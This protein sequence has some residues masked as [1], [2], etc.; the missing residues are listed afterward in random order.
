MSEKDRGDTERFAIFIPIDVEITDTHVRVE[1]LGLASDKE[2][3]EQA[4]IELSDALHAESWSLQE[5]SRPDGREVGEKRFYFS[6]DKWKAPW[7]P[8]GPK[9]NWRTEANPNEPIN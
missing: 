8:K 4:S 7:Q 3:A 6:G 1:T 9:P 5:I 2:A